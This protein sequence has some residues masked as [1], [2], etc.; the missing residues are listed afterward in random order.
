MSDLLGMGSG[1]TK[2]S[3]GSAFPPLPKKLAERIQNLEFVDM[4]ELRP[5]QWQ[6]VL[7]PEADPHKFVI[8]P[9]HE[10]ARARR[11]PVEDI[12]T[13]SIC[14]TTFMAAVGQKHPAMM[15]EMLAY[16]QHILRAQAEYEGQAWREYDMCFRQIAAVAGNKIWSQPDTQTYNLCFVGRA[17]RVDQA[18]G[19]GPAV[20]KYNQEKAGG[21]AKTDCC[22]IFNRDGSRPYSTNCRYRHACCICQGRHPAAQCKK[23]DQR[24]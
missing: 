20:P 15:G 14:F 3:I 23:A 7:E 6:E 2:V 21:K 19:A 18:K 13:W 11:R 9:G 1:A 17:R 16:M 10:I 8:L 4:A 22:L 24:S 5:I 12:H